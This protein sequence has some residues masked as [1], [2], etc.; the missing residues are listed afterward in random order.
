[1]I[2]NEGISCFEA[3]DCPSCGAGGAVLHSGIRDRLFGAPGVWSVR[4]CSQA[5]CGLGWL[6]PQPLETEIGQLYTSYYTH[7]SAEYDDTAISLD[8]FH[9][10]GKK[11]VIKA[12][13]ARLLP[14]RRAQFQTDLYHL[15]GMKPGRVLEVG[16]GSGEFLLAA[17]QAGWDANGIDF[18]ERAIATAA[19]LPGVNAIVSDLA[20][21]GYPPK[22]FDALVMNNVIEHLPRP[23]AVFDECFRV[24]RPGGRLVMITPNLA[25]LGHQTFGPDWRGLEVPRHLCIYTNTAIRRLARQ[26]GFA[27]ARAFSTLG[28]SIESIANE[29]A[30]IASR[31]GRIAPKVKTARLS[32]ISTVWA[33][34]GLSRSEF[35]VLVAERPA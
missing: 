21:A 6:D 25:S 16:C 35:L 26:A 19:K 15:Q 13:L 14:W 24:L 31:S 33:L 10:R 27:K 12:M 2:V 18:D 4:Q 1:M 32:F 7:G 30:K 20:G 28:N 9:T 22:S 17:A 11:R 29:S 5:N 23:A 8:A 34:L 3:L